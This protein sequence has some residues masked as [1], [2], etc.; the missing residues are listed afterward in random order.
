[1]AGDTAK[2][3]AIKQQI[4][5]QVKEFVSGAELA[6]LLQRSPSPID[7]KSDYGSLSKFV[8]AELFEVLEEAG[9]KGRDLLYRIRS[10]DSPVN[11]TIQVSTDSLWKEF[12]SPRGRNTLFFDRSSQHV[13]VNRLA[14]PLD[15]SQ[16]E[17]PR[18]S[19][20]E[21]NELALGF[22][23]A[24]EGSFSS[25][26]A[27]KIMPLILSDRE[28]KTNDEWFDE[29]KRLDSNLVRSWDEYRIAGIEEFFRCRL[30]GIVDAENSEE[31]IEH[32]LESLRESRKNTRNATKALH[33]TRSGSQLHGA[34]YERILLP[35]DVRALILGAV[36]S[37]DDC[38]LRALRVPAGALLDALIKSGY[39]R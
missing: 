33:S 36:S 9:F 35:R 34:L 5:S 7:Y 23:G 38:E 22:F 17:L 16:I 11:P 14:I 19:K 3:S 2:I 8:A 32:N 6:L 24:Y 18:I 12:A 28:N 10:S 37:L 15:D 27:E 21:L 20:S 4:L 30:L 39:R 29:L 13:Q 25:A 31:V 26:I 1:M